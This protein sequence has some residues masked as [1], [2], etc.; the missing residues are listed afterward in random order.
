MKKILITG[1]TGFI[2]RPLCVELTKHGHELTL[3]S[4]HPE[5]IQKEWGLPSR[6][7]AWDMEHEPCPISLEPFDVIINL[8]GES[9]GEGRWTEE[10]KKRIYESR[11]NSTRALGKALAAR[12][13]PLPLLISASAIGYYP[14]SEIKIQTERNAAGDRNLAKAHTEKDGSG[15]RNL[16]K[17]YTEKD[18]P[19][20]H[21]LAQV[22]RDW[23]AEVI[24]CPQVKREL[25]LRFAMVLGDGGGALQKILT[26][27]LWGG[28]TIFGS[29][30]QY[31]SWIHREDLIAVIQQAF[32]DER[33][34]GAINCA[35]PHPCTQETFQRTLGEVVRRPTLLRVPKTVI[36]AGLG[37]M[38]DLVLESQRVLPERLQRLDYS[39]KYP[40]LQSALR[41]ATNVHPY[42]DG[43]VVC[44]R[45][46][47]AQFIPRPLPDVFAFFSKPENLERITPPLLN[48][49]IKKSSS[50]EVEDGTRIA[51]KL[52][53]RGVPLHWETLIK[54]W[55]NEKSFVDIQEKGP[56]SIWHHRHEFFPVPGGTLMTDEVHYRLPLGF[57]GD[58]VGA[59][60]V[61]RDVRKIFDFR[62]QAIGE[63][64]EAVPSG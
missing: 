56:Y 16:A 44:H 40:D 6:F 47:T 9:I 52:K 28:G 17:A 50:E 59:P 30:Q 53:V 64:F 15:D 24:A 27:T 42:K 55:Q 11:V 5:K 20:D 35:T 31:M 19:G 23:E 45:L 58:A 10:R 4:R 32:D 3:V 22:C 29:G 62:R 38:A 13:A 49:H 46:S 1:G 26:P 14:Y 51:Y 36:R 61:R 63:F 54:E 7:V 48:F 8:A 43:E 39:Y 12:Q 25:R 21:F 34:A 60:L 57:L 41:E 37:E 33:Y 18:G 2:G